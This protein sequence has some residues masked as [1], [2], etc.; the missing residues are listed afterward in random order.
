MTA[1]CQ[2]DFYVLGSAEQSPQQL[3]CRLAMM[4]WEKG[5][6][7]AVMVEDQDQAHTLDE[8]MW[9]YPAGRFLPHA[10]ASGTSTAPVRIGTTLEGMPDE[11]DVVINLTSREISKPEQFRR[12]LEIVPASDAERTAS[13]NKFRAYRNQNLN[14]VSHPMGK[15]K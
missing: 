8:L 14:P 7:I 11:V 5:H 9:E 13:R 2:V 3:A 1:G 6:R 12:L 10:L 4:A 15:S